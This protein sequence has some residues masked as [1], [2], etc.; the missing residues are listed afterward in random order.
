MKCWTEIAE[1]SLGLCPDALRGRFGGG[2]IVA[3]LFGGEAEMSGC[4]VRRGGE[5]AAKNFPEKSEEPGC[6]GR[7][8][9]NVCP[10]EGI[11]QRPDVPLFNQNTCMLYNLET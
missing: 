7:T 9:Q 6:L 11:N 10:K 2:L 8:L 1:A 5:A 4:G 3:I